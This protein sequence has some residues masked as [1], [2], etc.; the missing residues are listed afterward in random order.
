[1]KTFL[2]KFLSL[3]AIIFIV[4]GVYYWGIAPE[5]SG[6]LGNLGK[7]P[8]GKNNNNLRS[9]RKN[10]LKTEHFLNCDNPDSIANYP[11]ANIGDSFSNCGT[12][13]YLN[14]LG[15]Y[16][17]LPICNIVR[18]TFVNP[19]DDYIALLNN[20]YF[21]EG[22]IVILESVERYFLYRL[23]MAD[24][25]HCQMPDFPKTKAVSHREKQDILQEVL[26]WIRLRCN[27]K[28]PV[29]HYTLSSDCFTSN[30]Y[31]RDLYVYNEDIQSLYY[32]H[33]KEAL[34][35][36]DSIKMLSMKHGVHLYFLICTDKYD[37]YEPLIA[38]HHIVSKML[39]SLPEADYIINPKMQIREAISNGIKD[40]YK[41][42]NT[43]TSDIGGEIF[44]QC[45]WL[46]LSQQLKSKN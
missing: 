41:V 4:I 32:D 28:N 18:K 5:I 38:E 36:L 7:I 12:E 14:Y 40:V 19:I 44:S 1:M 34:D 6:D 45:L 22:Q 15:S 8:F 10:A 20:G 35:K 46:R 43:H 17:P 39:D 31:S 9:S 2:P 30:R 23:F 3:F 33:K 24:L 26:L 25:N 42:N 16:S 27:F 29:L 37:A 21:K 11:I 13:G